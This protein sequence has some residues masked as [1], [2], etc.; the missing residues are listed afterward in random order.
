MKFLIQIFVISLFLNGAASYPITSYGVAQVELLERELAIVE[1][2]VK[3]AQV[4]LAQKLVEQS[5]CCFPTTE[6]A[7]KIIELS[8]AS[9]FMHNYDAFAN[10]L[11]SCG[12]L[13]ASAKSLIRQGIIKTADK[14]QKELKERIESDLGVGLI[15]FSGGVVLGSCW[16]F[17][18]C[19]K[20]FKHSSL[21]L[22]VGCLSL[23]FL[24]AGM[25]QIK[26][27]YDKIMQEMHNLK[28][29][30][31]MATLLIEHPTKECVKQP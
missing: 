28:V 12:P 10:S 15:F 8:T 6:Y 29:L 7:L 16:S 17:W 1:G 24:G 4:S 9:C 18:Y 31:A 26:I 23:P 30:N 11:A 27:T 13:C 22:I 19:C 5:P 25:H 21:K 2:Q 3:I 20:L 14:I